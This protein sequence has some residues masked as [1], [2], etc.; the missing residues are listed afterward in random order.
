MSRR[1]Q[2]KSAASPSSHHLDAQDV[3][4]TMVQIYRKTV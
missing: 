4:T 3:D 2:T 1:Q